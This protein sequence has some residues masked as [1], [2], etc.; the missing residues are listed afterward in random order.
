MAL[1]NT[2]TS[3]VSKPPFWCYW[4]KQMRS[5]QVEGA[6]ILIPHLHDTAHSC[7]QCSVATAWLRSK[8]PG[9]V[10]PFPKT[11]TMLWGHS[12]LQCDAG[13]QYQ[14]ATTFHKV[15]ETLHRTLLGALFKNDWRVWI[16]WH[17]FQNGE[18][19]VEVLFA[20]TLTNLPV[21]RHADRDQVNRQEECLMC[22]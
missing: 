11:F 20:S 1:L 15:K 2:L 4:S 18:K 16:T 6:D 9:A 3:E 13:S 12:L 5:I 22:I 19:M 10:I 7:S 17:C 8:W 14:S 21:H